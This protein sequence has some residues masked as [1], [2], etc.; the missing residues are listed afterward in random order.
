L[1][2]RL[3]WRTRERADVHSRRIWG[4]DNRQRILAADFVLS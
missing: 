3:V 2:Y 1:D 4:E